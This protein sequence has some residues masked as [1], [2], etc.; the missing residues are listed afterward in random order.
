M[1]AK[2]SGLPS[3]SRWVSCPMPTRTGVLSTAGAMTVDIVS[4]LPV[5]TMPPCR[6]PVS[7][8]WPLARVVLE[9]H[10]RLDVR[11]DD[12]PR[13]AVALLGDDDFQHVLQVASGV[14]VLGAVEEHDG[15]GILFNTARLAQVR[16]LR[17]AL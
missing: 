15:V 2:M 7:P 6:P 1:P 4:R 11:Q 9:A 10:E 17:I 13:G 14:L 3:T 16:Q 5:R 12:A 8:Q